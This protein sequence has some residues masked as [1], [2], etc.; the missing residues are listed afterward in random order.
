MAQRRGQSKEGHVR[1]NRMSHNQVQGHECAD[2]GSRLPHTTPKRAAMGP[3]HLKSGDLRC[4]NTCRN[5]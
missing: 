1:I 5:R 3:Q 4:G 2:R